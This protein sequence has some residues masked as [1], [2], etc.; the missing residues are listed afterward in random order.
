MKELIKKG[1]NYYKNH[2]EG[3]TYLIAGGLATVLN[4]VLFAI[5]TYLCRINY[6][7]SNIIAIIITVLFQ[8]FSNKFF[9]FKTKQ[10][11]FKENIKEFFSFI[12]CRLVTMVLDQVLMKIGVE[13]LHINELIAKV[14]INVIVIVA[15]YIFSKLFI[16]KKHNK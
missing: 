9:V 8:Y 1:I 16:F 13:I 14:I 11:T 5:L 10:N 15:N 3:I 12:S 2:R 4:I 7:I 6:E